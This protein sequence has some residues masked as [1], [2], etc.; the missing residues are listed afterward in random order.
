MLYNFFSVKTFVAFFRIIFFS[1][2]DPSKRVRLD[3]ILSGTSIGGSSSRISM[4][5][6]YMSHMKLSNKPYTRKDGKIVM[7]RASSRPQQTN[8]NNVNGS[9][10]SNASASNIANETVDDDPLEFD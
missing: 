3:K 8:S 1:L 2:L 9:N 10:D 4:G 6:D 5:M 7:E